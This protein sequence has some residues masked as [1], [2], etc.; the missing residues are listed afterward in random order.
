MNTAETDRI[1][2]K[3]GRIWFTAGVVI[4][5]LWI[6]GIVFERLASRSIRLEAEV[7]RQRELG[8]IGQ[9]ITNFASVKHIKNYSVSFKGMAKPGDTLTAKGVVKR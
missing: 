4:L 6:A 2:S 8:M 5:F 1:I 9:M 7:Q 3:A